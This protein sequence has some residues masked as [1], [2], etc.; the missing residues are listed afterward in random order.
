MKNYVVFLASF[1]LVSCAGELTDVP[2]GEGTGKAET[3]ELKLVEESFSTLP[4]WKEKK[5]FWFCAS[6]WSKLWA[7]FKEKF[8]K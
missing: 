4:H 1:F 2:I 7:C 3:L 5:C 8:S 6:L